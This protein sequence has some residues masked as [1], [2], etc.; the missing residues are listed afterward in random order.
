MIMAENT[1][2]NDLAN[3]NKNFQ[4]LLIGT[5]SPQAFFSE[6]KYEQDKKEFLNIFKGVFP[7][8][9]FNNFYEEDAVAAAWLTK[10]RYNQ[11]ME[12][13]HFKKLINRSAAIFT[14]K[15][16]DTLNLRDENVQENDNCAI[17]WGIEALNGIQTFDS[18][19]TRVRLASGVADKIVKAL[20]NGGAKARLNTHG[21][22]T[23]LVDKGLGKDLPKEDMRRFTPRGMGTILVIPTS[24]DGKGPLKK[25]SGSK[26]SED[27]PQDYD[28]L[29]KREDW[30]FKDSLIHT[31]VH[32]KVGG[33]NRLSFDKTIRTEYA[34]GLEQIYKKSDL[35]KNAEKKL[36]MK[37]QKIHRKEHLSE[38]KGQAINLINILEAGQKKNLF[39]NFTTKWCLRIKWPPFEKKIIATSS[40]SRQ[41]LGKF[42]KEVEQ[43]EA[44]LKDIK[45][46]K[47]DFIAIEGLLKQVKN[48]TKEELSF[49]ECLE[50]NEVRVNASDENTSAKIMDPIAKNTDNQEVDRAVLVGIT[51]DTLQGVTN[52]QVA[53]ELAGIINNKT[54]EI[55][56]ALKNYK[57][58]GKAPQIN[59]DPDEKNR[60]FGIDNHHS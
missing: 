23:Q 33:L 32:A 31:L 29:L 5:V 46:I 25:P 1:N 14:G 34:K 27:L 51:R 10:L 54:L 8:G 48:L 59:P 20:E 58:V 55:K 22:G 3:N 42:L 26:I 24:R 12:D 36:G 21:T 28:L 39:M 17:M 37:L 44:L 60:G 18:G 7:E 49:F 41:G 52:A 19:T 15:F 9:S 35:V 43:N 4:L 40:D 50:G 13:E 45:S 53:P 2:I 38:L 56:Q 16:N 11:D 30:G 47:N 57:K 6:S